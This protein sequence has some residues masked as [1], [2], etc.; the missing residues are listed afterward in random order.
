MK[1][2]DTIKAEIINLSPEEFISK[3]I[4]CPENWYFKNI[5]QIPEDQIIK[6][7]DQFKE[8]VANSFGLTI[9]NI[10]MVGSGK[11]GFSLAPYERKLYKEF[12]DDSSIRNISDLDIAIISRELFNKY[13]DLLRQS[14]KFKFKYMYP[15]IQEGIYRG[16]INEKYLTSIEGCRKD[17]NSI[18]TNSKKKLSS[19]LYIRHEVTYRIYRRWNDFHDYHISS[20][21]KIKK[22]TPNAPSV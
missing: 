15:A 3:Y 5:L 11:M 16:Y 2:I 19:E 22:E 21:N 14:F 1:P 8:I 20:I 13:W 6:F 9:D 12:N 7:G 18:A 17:W 10:E 4:K